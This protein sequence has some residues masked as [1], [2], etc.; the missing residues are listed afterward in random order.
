MGL[1]SFL[2]PAARRRAEAEKVV[3]EKGWPVS[4]PRRELK[5]FF[6]DE[7]IAITPFKTPLGRTAKKVTPCVDM[8]FHFKDG[9]IIIDKAW[10][11]QSRDLNCSCRQGEAFKVVAN[12]FERGAIE[13]ILQR[14][15]DTLKSGLRSRVFGVMADEREAAGLEIPGRRKT[16]YRDAASL[17]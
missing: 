17:P 12:F 15:A 16:K 9:R 14:E 8:Y 13:A 4:S 6:M 11:C 5:E 7:E 10:C 2:S 3:W 1:F